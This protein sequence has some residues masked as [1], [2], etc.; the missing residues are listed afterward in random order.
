MFITVHNFNL[1]ILLYVFIP[2]KKSP[3]NTETFLSC[4]MFVLLSVMQSWYLCFVPC[5]QYTLTNTATCT[6]LT[7][8]ALCLVTM[9]TAC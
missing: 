3:V 4:F 7:S 6:I 5:E 8:Y 9:K 1:G 2:G